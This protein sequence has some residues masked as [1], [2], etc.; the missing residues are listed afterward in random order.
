[1]KTV[2]AFEAK[3]H[4][5]QL[6]SEVEHY[7][8]EVVIEKRGKKIALL[9]PFKKIYGEAETAKK[10]RILD[11]FRQIRACQKGKP[12]YQNLKEL[13]EEGRKR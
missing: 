12:G 11:G 5:S 2:G 4:L 8:E 7:Q 10:H 1:M 9:I 13:V 6:L 3:T